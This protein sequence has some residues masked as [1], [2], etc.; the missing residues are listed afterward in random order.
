MSK[1]SMPTPMPFLDVRVH[2][3][4]LKP[5]LTGLCAG[6]EL[7]KWR[8]EQL[9]DHL[10][11]WLP[12][13]ALR[14]SER[15]SI[16][17][18]T[19]VKMIKLAARNIFLTDSNAK[20]GEFGE[21]L[22]HV[23]IRQCFG[24][25][26]AISKIYYKDGPNETVKGFDAV[27]VVVVKGSLELW[28]GEVKFYGRIGTAIADVVKELQ[29]HMERDYLREEFA[30]IVRKIDPRW[31]QASLLTKL[32]DPNSSLD[33]IFNRICVP[34]MLTYNS[35]CIIKH[36]RVCAEFKASFIDE[37]KRHHG[38]FSDK[39]LPKHVR[40]HLFLLPLKNKAD[41]AKILLARL[42]LWQ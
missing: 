31:P 19:A 38:S 4:D 10:M 41:L 21:L 22:L 24:S 1:G 17:S 39:P 20:R 3:V 42:R 12:E 37:V 16:N 14:H 33:E 15:Q 27:H 29:Q 36:S 34:V 35:P 2:D 9:A 7:G 28:L 23:A 13:F 25:M 18:A 26:P 40:V 32:L 8:D 30:A 11:E 5:G 6:Y